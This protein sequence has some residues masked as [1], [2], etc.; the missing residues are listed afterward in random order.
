MRIAFI[1]GIGW[2]Y[3]VDSV[4]S[5]P[6]GGSQSALCYLSEALA[7]QEHEVFLFNQTSLPGLSDGVVCLPLES[8]STP[9]LQSLDA[10]ILLNDLGRGKLFRSELNP[11]A[12][13][14]L[15]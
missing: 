8:V 6:L 1:D 4:Q 15:G 2:D 11:K 14:S 3:R 5:R 13:L 7:R 12:L 10:L 9:F